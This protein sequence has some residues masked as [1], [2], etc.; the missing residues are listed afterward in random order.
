MNILLFYSL[1]AIDFFIMKK[2]NVFIGNSV[3]TFSAMHMIHRKHL[4]LPYVVYNG[5]NIPLEPIMFNQN[6]IDRPHGRLTWILTVDGT[7]ITEFDMIKASIRSAQL[8]TNLL[9]FCIYDGEQNGF[10]SWMENHGIVIFYH[11][12]SFKKSFT[13]KFLAMGLDIDK[14]QNLIH[15]FAFLDIPLLG[16]TDEYLLVT[17]GHVLFYKNVTLNDF[18][19]LP[20]FV[21]CGYPDKRPNEKA[22][23]CLPGLLL[24]R[25]IELASQRDKMI[26]YIVNYNFVLSDA[27]NF[28][29]LFYYEI[30]FEEYFGTK[31]TFA[32]KLLNW[33]PHFTGWDHNNEPKIVRFTEYK[34]DSLKML[35]DSSISVN[36]NFHT[37][38]LRCYLPYSSCE[39]IYR[40]YVALTALI[41][42]QN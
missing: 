5:G 24:V 21:S 7:F 20:Q 17:N 11:K 27:N 38:L 28:G 19:P 30:F 32:S 9:I 10:T 41:N 13:D 33:L 23:T 4:G 16:F 8:N 39:P 31:I 6:V 2:S 25:T 37:D 36:E 35:Y 42:K 1:A 22:P 29:I 3:S 18:Q 14:A 12:L 15:Q 40:F 26:D 34:I